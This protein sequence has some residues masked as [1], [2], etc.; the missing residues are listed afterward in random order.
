M[1]QYSAESFRRKLA[2]LEALETK[3]SNEEVEKMK[4]L[5]VE[6]V[7]ALRNVF[8]SSLDRMSLWNR[9]SNGLSIAAAKSQGKVDK[10][11]V[12]LLDYVRAEAHIVASNES[13]I[14]ISD[15]LL[16]M[17]PE[18]Q[19]MFIRICAEYR[20]LLCLQAREDVEEYKNLLKQL[21]AKKATVENDG[22]IKAWEAKV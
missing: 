10:F 2:G 15:K 9:I 20:M 17:S 21:G 18:Q 22:T 19:R 3:F 12:G 13:L 6:L 14:T 16:G 4:I 11:F 1:V 8:G 5:G 7:K